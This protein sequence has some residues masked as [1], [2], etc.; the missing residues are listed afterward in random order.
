MIMEYAEG[1][2]LFNY[3]IEKGNLS[4]EE[5]R[6]IFHQI[7]DGIYYLHRMGICHRDLKPENILFDTKE[8]KRIKIIDFGLSNLYIYSDSNKKKD[9]LETPCGS[10]GY[11]PPE[12]IF[13]L[14]Y[15][16]FMTDIWSCGI[17]LYAMLF[18]CLP[19]DDYEEEKLYQKIVEGIYEYPDDIHISQEAKNL[20]D[21]ILVVNPN[22]RANIKEIKNNKWFLKNYT[23]IIGLYNSICEI[24]VNNLI[25]KEMVKLG[26][27]YNKIIK[28]IKNNNHNNL[29]TLYYLLVKKKLKEGIETESDLISNCFKKYIG[30]QYNKLKN[31]HKSLNPINLKEIVYP[32]EIIIFDKEI[33]D[34][35]RD[36]K[37]KEFYINNLMDEVNKN[38]NKK[39]KGKIIT[40]SKEEKDKNIFNYLNIN[41]QKNNI[42]MKTFEA[43]NNNKLF[44]KIARLSKSGEDITIYNPKP[45]TKISQNMKKNK[46][47]TKVG[48]DIF[49]NLNYFKI[50]NN[51]FRVKKIKLDIKNKK[52]RTIMEDSNRNINDSSNNNNKMNTFTL[53]NNKFINYNNNNYII[54]L[55][56]HDNFTF[57]EKYNKKQMLKRKERNNYITFLLKNKTKHLNIDS[58]TQLLNNLKTSRIKQNKFM[59][60]SDSNSRIKSSPISKTKSKSNSKKDKI[61]QKKFLN[62]DTSRNYKKN[63]SRKNNIEKKIKNLTHEKII[64][65]HSN[66]LDKERNLLI[67]KQ[68]NLN[69]KNNGIKYD[70]PKLKNISNNKI[71]NKNNNIISNKK[72][73]KIKPLNYMS[74]FINNKI[75]HRNYTT[76]L[77]NQK[78]KK[79]LNLTT[80]N[81]KSFSFAKLFKNKEKNK[82]NEMIKEKINKYNLN[83]KIEK[84]IKNNNNIKNKLKDINKYSMFENTQ[85]TINIV[86]TC[87]KELIDISNLKISSKNKNINQKDVK[88]N[89]N[90]DK[91]HRKI[92]IENCKPLKFKKIILLKDIKKPYTYRKNQ[93]FLDELIFT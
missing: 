65:K 30:K 37:K 75:L 59:A 74:I 46:N 15:D 80:K 21:S 93:K 4:E 39:P 52:N 35:Y 43:E 66:T 28:D 7:I 32:K 87:S 12:M 83:N 47:K 41:E 88:N 42:L 48:R 3:I 55:P 33:P 78:I 89:K 44:K 90:N 1:G 29:T 31:N 57:K 72:I 76:N 14:K 18:G 84:K 22:N 92:K 8:K 16:G 45:K 86:D 60:I 23:P 64:I 9:Y 58:I 13:G 81:D 77:E 67:S 85:N 27:N 34:T 70:L 61:Q 40:S 50:K 62:F 71:N 25:V 17:I 49:I 53:E 11:A 6:D 26:Y 20:I 54:K 5:S 56:K 91:N 63:D 19:F 79:K 51:F 68:N 2:E 38:D 73:N 69:L 82:N 36:N 24:P 10:P